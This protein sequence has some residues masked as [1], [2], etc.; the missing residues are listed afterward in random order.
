MK[1]LIGKDK[2]EPITDTKLNTEGRINVTT[3]GTAGEPRL[4]SLNEVTVLKQTSFLWNYVR[5]TNMSLILNCLN[6]K[7]ICY[8]VYVIG[9]QRM[10][11]CGV[12]EFEFSAEKFKEYVFE[13]KPRFIPISMDNFNLIKDL[14]LPDMDWKPIVCFD[15]NEIQREDI[16]FFVDRGA[17]VLNLYGT[18]ELVPPILVGINSVD[19]SDP[20]FT[21]VVDVEDDGRLSCDGKTTDDLFELFADEKNRKFTFKGKKE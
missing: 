5:L 11:N 8:W 12:I 6:S 18:T 3:K 14:N 7:N 21:Y 16:D 9:L 4:I 2:E 19:F 1:Y 15:L 17:K 10:T 20:T 13:Y